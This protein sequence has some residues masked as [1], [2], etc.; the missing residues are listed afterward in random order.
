[1]AGVLAVVACRQLVGIGDQAPGAGSGGAAT[2]CGGFP[3]AAGAC[4][5]CVEDACCA[6]AT[7]C[8]GDVTCGPTFDCLAQCAGSDDGCRSACFTQGNGAI[9]A[10]AS[11]QATSCSADCGLQCGGF[12]G[13]TLPGFGSQCTSCFVAQ[14]CPFA[15]QCA[16]SESCFAYQFC[17]RACDPFDLV[18]QGNC[19][20]SNPVTLPDGGLGFGPGN[21]TCGPPCGIGTDWSCVGHAVWPLAAT[22]PIAFQIAVSDGSGNPFSGVTVRACLGG[23]ADCVM[24]IQTVTSDSQG[25]ATL[26]TSA[27]FQ[28]YVELTAS[29]YMTQL[30]YVYPFLAEATDPGVTVPIGLS[31]TAYIAELGSAT[32]V[33]LDPLLG[34]VAASPKDC[35]NNPAPG[36]AFSGS[37]LGPRAQPFYYVSGTPTTHATATSLPTSVGGFSNVAPGLIT[38]IA[39]ANGAAFATVA[40]EVRPN[41]LTIIPYL[42]PTP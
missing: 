3:W 36:V 8:R 6:E 13:L 30:E 42:V 4:G 32:G 23:D 39:S 37:P 33:P 9:A 12:F 7:A 14:S 22:S 17:N 26:T 40:V 35:T 29:G 10:L 27:P 5:S 15:T 31:T 41:A 1:V 16:Q 20:Y 19:A 38:L 24:P 2:T 18:C 21:N 11:C 34:I 28:G 25:L